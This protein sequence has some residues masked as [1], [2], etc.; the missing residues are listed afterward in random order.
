MKH[1]W[2]VDHPYYCNEGNYYASESV[3]DEFKRWQD[4]S[5]EYKDADFDMN[6]IFRFDWS[7]AEGSY[8][9]DDNYRNGELL[10]FW[11][12]QRK[13]LYRYTKVDVCRA[14]EQAVIDFLR[15]RWEHM[16]LLWEPISNVK[17]NAPAT[18]LQ[19]KI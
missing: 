1:L 16:R 4:F 13:G 11:M 5:D 12:G 9:G 17:G 10:I 7:E 14:D 8:T 2:E 15:P 3:G 19:E 18:A 6:L